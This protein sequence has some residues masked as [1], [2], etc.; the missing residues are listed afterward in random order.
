MAQGADAG[1]AGATGK[2]LRRRLVIPLL[3]LAVAAA[4]M[5]GCSGGSKR[6]DA[7]VT[8]SI[9]ARCI[10]PTSAAAK[11]IVHYAA[12]DGEEV[13]AYV[14]GPAAGKHVSSSGTVGIVIVHE[15]NQD[16]CDSKSWAMTFSGLGYLAIAPTVDGF[17][18]AAEVEASVAYLR[19]H[20]AKQVVLLGASMGGTAVLLTAVEVKPPVQAVVSVSGPSAYSSM[21]ALSAA[22]KL[23]VPVFYSAGELDTDFAFDETNLYHATTEKDKVLD[24]VSGD[25]SHGFDLLYALMPRVKA[26]FLEHIH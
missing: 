26:F 12:A 24:I 16:L 6:A 7:T 20:G 1:S 21:D 4:G 18:P 22:P 11:Q 19:Q 8:P 9:S 13:E 3:V 14:A 23:T 15:S 2:A 10:S 17:G 25:P 5:A